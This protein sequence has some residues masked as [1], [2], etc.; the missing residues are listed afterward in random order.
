MDKI[1]IKE[2]VIVEGRDDTRAVLE[3]VN[4]KTIETHGFGITKETYNLIKKAYEETGIIIFTDP[5]YSGEEIRK[6][7]KEKFPNAKEAFL[8]EDKATKKGDIG[9][10][11]AKPQDITSALLKARAEVNTKIDEF[12][13]KDLRDNGLEGNAKRREALGQV[14]GIGYGNNK[15]FLKKLNGFS[16][17]REEFIEGLKKI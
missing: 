11:N 8:V 5:D 9:I 4:C 13:L 6:K 17:T 15:S 1:S 2:I 3:S 14:L 7:L 16:I 10:E 12:T